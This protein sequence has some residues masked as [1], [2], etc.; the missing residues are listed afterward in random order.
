MF[1]DTFLHTSLLPHN[2]HS[3][4]N[5]QITPPPPLTRLLSIQI[6][7]KMSCASAGAQHFEPKTLLNA[8]VLPFLVVFAEYALCRHLTPCILFRLS[9]TSL[10]KNQDLVLLPPFFIFLRLPNRVSLFSNIFP[11]YRLELS[12]RGAQFDAGRRHEHPYK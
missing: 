4:I 5:Y 12:D 11:S 3:K 6:S 1:S 8:D 2:C 7:E 9:D 10:R